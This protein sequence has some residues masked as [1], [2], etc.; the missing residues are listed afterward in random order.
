MDCVVNHGLTMAE[1][2][3]RV[4]LNIG[5]ST[6]SSIIQAFR[7]KSLSINTQHTVMCKFVLLKWIYGIH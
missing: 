2:G 1:A 5:R 4:Q 6:I 7:N 3:Q